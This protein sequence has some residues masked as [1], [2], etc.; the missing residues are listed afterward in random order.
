MFLAYYPF[1]NWQRKRYWKKQYDGWVRW[2]TYLPRPKENIPIFNEE[3]LGSCEYCG[4]EK[5]HRRAEKVLP[6][7]FVWRFFEN[8]TIG[9]TYFYSFRCVRCATELYRDKEFKEN[10]GMKKIDKIFAAEIKEQFVD[11][12]S[13]VKTYCSE[14]LHQVNRVWSRFTYHPPHN[15]FFPKLGEL[16]LDRVINFSSPSHVGIKNPER[17]NE[18]M[19][20]LKTLVEPGYYLGN[21]FFAWFRNNSMF[22]DERFRVVFE[23]HAKSEEERSGAWNH[24]LHICAVY[25][26]LRVPGEL[27]I[28]GSGSLESVNFLINYFDKE[29]F[30]KKIYVGDEVGIYAPPINLLNVCLPPKETKVD[31]QILKETGGGKFEN[32]AYLQ[33]GNVAENALDAILNKAASSLVNGSIVI[34]EFYD[35]AGYFRTHKK[36][37]D[38]WADARNLKIF[39]LPT[40]QG[41]LINN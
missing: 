15:D 32:I 18:L 12:V 25:H 26:A 9:E 40:G 8:Q 14:K 1:A 2:S 22:E 17:F 5:I 39:P 21:S 38:G 28:L 6:G 31:Y 29:M 36:I 30:P 11:S 20:E 3:A 34:F 41:L 16:P 23:E 7:I 35:V 27:L 33:V 37:A 19:N 13:N 4:F 24:Y 10:L